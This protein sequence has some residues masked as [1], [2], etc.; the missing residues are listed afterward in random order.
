MCDLSIVV[1]CYFSRKIFNFNRAR[2]WKERKRK[3]TLELPVCLI[4]LCVCERINPF[5]GQLSRQQVFGQSCTITQV[6]V[7][8]GC[9]CCCCCCWRATWFARLP[10]GLTHTHTLAQAA[11]AKSSCIY[12]MSARCVLAVCCGRRLMIIILRARPA[13]GKQTGSTHNLLG[14]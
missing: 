7:R 9:C 10:S 12:H 8:L 3:R 5:C 13:T 6:C 2:R 14:F 1:C 11:V 4:Q